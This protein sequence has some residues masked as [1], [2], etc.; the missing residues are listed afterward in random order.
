MASKKIFSDYA[1]IGEDLDF[2]KNV[3]IEISEKGLIEEIIESKELGEQN[4][5]GKD[6]SILIPCFINSHT[7]IA[8]NFGKELGLNK[9]I[10]DVVS[11]SESIKHRILKESADN[12][13]IRGIQCAIDE[14][15][16]NGITFFIDFR[17][18]GINGVELLRR[19]SEHSPIGMKILGRPTS[20]DNESEVFKLADGLGFPSCSK[21]NS[22]AVKKLLKNGSINNKIIAAHISETKREKYALDFL[23]S[24]DI[25]D[26]FVHGTHFTKE[27]L[28][29]IKNQNKKIVICPQSNGY[30]GVGFPPLKEM[31]ELGLEISLGTDNLMA[32]KPDFF[33]EMRYIYKMSKIEAPNFS[34]MSK[35]LLKMAT[36]N[37]AKNLRLEKERGS[38]S[39]GKFADF[40]ALNLN[41]SNYFG[42]NDKNI[43]DIIVHRTSSVN[44]KKVYV[45]GHVAF[46]RE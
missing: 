21:I 44:I 13:V 36:I 28:I 9:P 41:D 33:E 1:L 45:K 22:T 35:D 11:G 38:I 19:A 25:V 15:L 46:E 34:I 32:V 8:D 20:T 3:L 4:L 23:L 26:V 14:M 6:K 43:L 30:F 17:E 12:L 37:A 10:K 18:N 27:D 31:L 7:H 5:L 29:M 24:E 39:E 42:I 16:S 40:F 2:K